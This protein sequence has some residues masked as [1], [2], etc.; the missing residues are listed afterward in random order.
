M[1]VRV[2]CTVLLCLALLSAAGFAAA[3][4]YQAG[5]VVKVEKQESRAPSRGTDAPMKAEVASY[6]VSIQL[7]DKVYVCNYDTYSEQ[8]ISWVEGKAV[9]ARVSGKVVYV[10][11][12]NG[13]EAKG[14]ILSTS[15][16]G[17]P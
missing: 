2:V 5:K 15:P 13:K 8:D 11:K 6:H 4:E 3:H 9:E 10:K 1:K 7:G 12:A 16:A 14:A 17:N